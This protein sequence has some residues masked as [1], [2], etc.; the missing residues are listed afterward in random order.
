MLLLLIFAFLVRAAWCLSL[1]TNESTLNDLPD[2][3][4]YLSLADNLLKGNG[5]RLYDPRFKDVVYAYR[6]PV[7]PLFIAACRGGVQS[8]RLAQ[9]AIDTSTILA[10][11]LISQALLRG[12]GR[13]FCALLAAALVALNPFLIYFC[14]L[15]LSETLF[16]ALLAWGML[17]LIVGG[18]GARMQPPIEPA[19]VYPAAGRPASPGPGRA[20]GALL[21]LAGG[22]LLAVAALVRPSA[23]PLPV[24][25]GIAAAFI[26]PLVQ[27]VPTPAATFSPGV[28]IRRARRHMSVPVGSTMLAV[29][30]LTLLPWAYRNH[31]VLG[32][33]IWTTTNGGVTLYDGFNPDATGASDQSF[34]RSMPQLSQMGETARSQYLTEKAKAYIRANPVRVAWLAVLKFARTWSPMPL[35]QEYGDW[36]HRAVGLLFSLPFDLCIFVGLLSARLS[37]PAKLFLLLPAMFFTCVH[38]MSVG[39]I[40]YRVPVE[41]LL[42]VMAAAGL[43]AVASVVGIWEGRPQFKR[44][45]DA[46]AP[47]GRL[48]EE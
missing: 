37:R 43:S 8:V 23:V 19:A 30:V 32:Q 1:P 16:T 20:I 35:S 33:W 3:R 41:P 28:G 39:S 34:V 25:M 24:I 11:F 40:R 45:G 10:V 18:R 42:S 9:A 46:T 15:I 22:F 2:Q 17:L 29:T 48:A 31:R 36:K 12:P 5:L 27:A 26:D 13:P 47:V 14:G 38:M 6:T 7:Y 4:E 44:A 21:W